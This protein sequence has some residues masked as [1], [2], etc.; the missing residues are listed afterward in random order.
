MHRAGPKEMLAD[1][2]GPLFGGHQYGLKLRE[3]EKNSVV[4]L[5][6]PLKTNLFIWNLASAPPTFGAFSPSIMLSIL[7]THAWEA[8]KA[9][10][11]SA[12]FRA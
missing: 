12:I 4:K 1:R 6:F 5:K 2:S 10:S 9:V 3:T 11:S 7:S 8:W